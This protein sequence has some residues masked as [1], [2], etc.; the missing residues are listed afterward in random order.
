METINAK[1][2]IKNAKW[3]ILI[4]ALCTLHFA[5]VLSGCVEFQVGGDIQQGRMALLYGDP[6]VALAHFQRASE[7]DPDYLLNLSILPE[8]VWTYVGRAYY[9][10]GKLPD[11]RKALEGASSR[12]EQDNLAKLYLGLVLARDGEQQRGLKEI[13]AGLKGLEDWLYHIEQYNPDG[14]FW[15]PARELRREIQRDR[16]MIGGKDV[17]WKELI[18]SGEWL[19]RE[20]EEEIDRV[21][22]DKKHD[23]MSN[24]GDGKGN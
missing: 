12:Y 1:G 18:A 19:G 13:E 15:D 9:A 24:D 22:R 4:F 14:R 23:I 3:K 20:F 7:L 17:N 10:T 5:I 8:G 11:A 6:K 2:K 21:T 16:A